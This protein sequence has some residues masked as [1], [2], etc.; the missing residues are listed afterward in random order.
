MQVFAAPRLQ[1]LEDVDT[2]SSG[3]H[4]EALGVGGELELVGW[5]QQLGHFGDL[6]VGRRQPWQSATLPTSDAGHASPQDPPA[7]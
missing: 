2:S 5:R 6:A 1:Q 3:G 7:P 4:E